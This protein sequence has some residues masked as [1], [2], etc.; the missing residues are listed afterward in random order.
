[1]DGSNLK[2]LNSSFKQ[3]N[4]QVFRLKYLLITAFALYRK[5]FYQSKL[6]AKSFLV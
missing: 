2:K 6:F 4:Y 5:I 1:M 3:L